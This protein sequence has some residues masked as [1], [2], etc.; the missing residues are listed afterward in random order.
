M[1]GLPAEWASMQSLQLLQ[2]VSAGMEGNPLSLL[3]NNSYMPALIGLNVRD[4]QLTVLP[5]GEQR[6][7]GLGMPVMHAAEASM[8]DAALL[9]TPPT[10]HIYAGLSARAIVHLDVSH[11]SLQALP[12]EWANPGSTLASSL[13]TLLVD[14]NNLTGRT[15]W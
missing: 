15:P 12:A 8:G 4:N 9:Q 11:N 14:N 10:C 13:D 5:I 1:G 3:A 7:P 6:A 2:V